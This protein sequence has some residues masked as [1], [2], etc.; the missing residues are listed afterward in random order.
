MFNMMLQI[1]DDGQLTDAKG[2]KVNFKNTV[3]IMT[4][5][6]GSD[7]IMKLSQKGTLGFG[8]ESDSG[9]ATQEVIKKN[10]MD[11]LREHFK[12]E[13]LNRI[14]ETI[15]FHPLTEAQVRQIVDI[16]MKRVQKRLD[17]KKIKLDI[18]S[19]AK[20]LLGK[21]GFDPNFGARPLKRVIQTE[22]LDPIAMNIVTGEIEGGDNIKVVTKKEELVISKK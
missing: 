7:M 16:Q 14:D 8:D 15:M 10:V 6:I 1:L 13:F 12:P 18:S 22:L 9:A 19:K 2:R 17:D 3:I 4:S 21:K 5:N 11:K 20:D